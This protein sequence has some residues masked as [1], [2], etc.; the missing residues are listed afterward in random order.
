MHSDLRSRL[1]SWIILLAPA[2][3][4]TTP[5]GMGAIEIFLL[6]ASA[7]S[8]RSLAAQRRL[9][10]PQTRW[11]ILAFV[12]HAALAVASVY[13]QGGRSAHID[14]PLRQALMLGAIGLVALARPRRDWFWY[15]VFIGA[16][17]AFGIALYQRFILLWDRAGGFHQIIMFGDIAMTLALLSLA[18]LPRFAGSRLAAL[19]YAG[20][21]C[22][23]G[24]SLLSVTRGGWVVLVLAFI[25]LLAQDRRHAAPRLLAVAGGGAVL[26]LGAYLI[27]AT[28]VAVR[29]AEI[30]RDLQLYAQG[31]I[32]TPIGTRLEMWRAALMMFLEHPLAGVGRA[33]FNAGMLDLIQRGVISPNVAEYQ[34]GH[35]ELL[36]ALATQGLPGALALLLMY[37]APL[38]FFLR[39][40]RR[41]DDSQPYA[42][43]GLLLV[44]AFVG[45]GLTQMLFSHHIG[46]AFYAVLVTI[47]AGLCLSVPARSATVA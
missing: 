46:A 43:A 20:F 15:G 35:N 24:A 40:L 30:T 13:W 10:L 39:Q 31:T 21:L 2:T 36:H 11:I 29:V 42:L 45:F 26:L 6:L 12:L 8:A 1:F 22:G 23:V 7:L 34:H 18:A 25:P 47:L 37:A 4:L 17:G 19:P 28:G 38:A 27:P 41:R 33:N 14:N 3:A 44:L 9:W 16:S 32:Y 5:D